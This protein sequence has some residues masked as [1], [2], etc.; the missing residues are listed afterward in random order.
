MRG[1][2]GYTESMF[3][4]SRLDDFVPAGHPLRPIRMW[5]NDAL[6]RMDAVFSRMYESD[7]KDGRPS[8]APEKLIRALLLQVL[9]SIRS[10]RML[11]EQ[12]SY[13]M[14]FRWFVGL[15]MDDEM[16]DQ[17]TFSQNRDRL[18]AHDVI[19]S[20]FNETVETARVRGYLSGEHFSVD[21]TLIQ[22]WA[23][24][25]SFAPRTQSDDDTSPDGGV[26]SQENWHGEKRSNDTHESST[27]SQARLFRKGRGTGAMLCYM[28]HVLTDNRHGLVVNA[29][30]TQANGTAERDTAADMLAD[31]ARF[32][33]TPVTVGAD[34]NYD[35]AGFVATCRAN[36]VTPHV[37]Q[38]DGRAGGS[39]IDERTTRW[40]G[41][42][43]SQ[44]KRKCIE[45]V[46]GWGKTVGRIRQAMYRG[47]Q[48]V[49]QLFLLTQAACNLTRMRTLA[50]KAA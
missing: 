28:G 36:C 17:S 41:Y 27:D 25:K 8:I 47:L 42:A 12:I 38:N 1:A 29:Q 6:G 45:Q 37:A 32:A 48:R 15:A 21:G 26:G 35:M 46:F 34:K 14:L 19:V 23:G 40:P 9:Y 50:V 16:W 10:E 3:T 49:D 24:H 7:A 4:I 39:A 20:L 31:A 5:L 33:G 2:D 43:I 18:L 30:V 11:L 44:R 22:A 13:N